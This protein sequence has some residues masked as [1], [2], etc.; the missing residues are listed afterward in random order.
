MTVHAQGV[1][2]R[3]IKPDNLLLTEDDVLKI[4]DFGVSEMFEKQSEM[5]T[6]KSAGSPA[7]LPP[8]LCVTRHGDISGKAADIWSMGVSLYCLRFGRIPFERTGVLE[9]YEAIKNDNV[10]IEPE[11]E[12]QFVD[13]IRRV[14]EKDPKQ[15]ITM[16]AL[17]VWRTSNFLILLAKSSQ[18]HPWVTKNGT[19]PLLSAEE[20]TADLVEPPSELEVN[21]AITTKM[22]NLLVMVGVV[23]LIRHLL[24]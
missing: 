12:P 11:N 6:A 20:N 4:V 21:H 24:H 17:R 10:E 7:F 22:G 13:L 2:H 3:D 15:R 14:L 8:E 9:L 19:D 1:V 5:M 23:S 18:E 16:A